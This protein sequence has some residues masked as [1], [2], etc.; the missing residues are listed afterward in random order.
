MMVLLPK[1][2]S[3]I[4]LKTET[5]I[6]KSLILVASLRSGRVFADGYIIVL[7]IQMEI[8]KDGRRMKIRKYEWRMLIKLEWR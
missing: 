1:E 2:V 8:C 6:A 5:I 3:S 4:N 7:K